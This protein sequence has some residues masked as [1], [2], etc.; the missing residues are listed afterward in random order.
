MWTLV[1]WTIV[2]G[3]SATIHFDWR[4]IATNIKSEQACEKAA[5]KLDY[6]PGSKRKLVYRCISS[7]G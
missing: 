3:T 1:L 6:D 5:R 2:T 7:D 4:P